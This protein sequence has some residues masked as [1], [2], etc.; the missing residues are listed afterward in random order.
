MPW[1]NFGFPGKQELQQKYP[2]PETFKKNIPGVLKY[3]NNNREKK[4]QK[5]G[6]NAPH[7]HPQSMSDSKD[8]RVPPR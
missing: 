6:A 5:S 8:N 2:I 1:R 7:S 3:K 4:W